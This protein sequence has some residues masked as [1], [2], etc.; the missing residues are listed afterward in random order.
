[1]LD[2]NELPTQDDLSKAIGAGCAYLII[3]V[4]VFFALIGF[5]SLFFARW[6]W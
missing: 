6:S 5:L 4:L 1:M 3:A 2:R